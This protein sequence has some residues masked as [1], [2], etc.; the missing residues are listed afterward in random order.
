MG[1]LSFTVVGCVSF[2]FCSMAT[3]GKTDLR[4]LKK[5]YQKD[6]SQLARNV[7]KHL[8]ELEVNN[9]ALKAS[10]S[11]LHINS[12]KKVTISPKRYAYVVFYSLRFIRRFRKIQKT[13]IQELEKKF[14]NTHIV[15]IAQRKI[16][17]PPK[18]NMA[19]RARSFT[20]TAVHDAII[21]DIVYPAEIVGRRVHFK[22]DGSRVMQI[23]FDEKH[24]EI[25]T[26]KLPT[27]AALARRLTGRAVSFGYMSNPALQQV[28]YIDGEK[29]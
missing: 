21:E 10:L 26:P 3:Q 23:F 6:A 2:L 1:C 24:R 9:A 22:Q 5:S 27:F 16:Q 11:S 28:T 19:K 12:V 13:L 7:A 15:F 25:T 14:P 29:L 8:Y 17:A 4:K 18:S 20:L